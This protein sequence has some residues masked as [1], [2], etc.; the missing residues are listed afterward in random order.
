LESDALKEEIKSIKKSMVD[1]ESRLL[2][3]TT[4]LE[5][6]QSDVSERLSNTTEAIIELRKTFSQKMK[7]LEESQIYSVSK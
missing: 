1:T 2:S 5:N 4:L 6:R 7:A 3:Q